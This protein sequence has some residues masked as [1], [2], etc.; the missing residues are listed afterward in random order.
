[1]ILVVDDEPA[2]R[3]L[4]RTVLEADGY[5]V[6]AVASADAALAL[7]ERRPLE[8]V[9]SDYSMPGLSGL[10]LLLELRARRIRVP[11]VLVT[12]SDPSEYGR[13]AAA[14]AV[15]GVLPKPLALADLRRTVAAALASP[16]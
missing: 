11:F 6:A 4:L 10:D 14:L 12:G 9:L 15:D 5:T 2:I 3:E 13:H 8:L 7:A 16:R 1:M